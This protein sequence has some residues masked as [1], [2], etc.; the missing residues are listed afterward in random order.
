MKKGPKLWGTMFKGTNHCLNFNIKLIKLE[1]EIIIS[2][3]NNYHTKRKFDEVNLT[4]RSKQEIQALIF[5]DYERKIIAQ[6]VNK[7]DS[8][9][10]T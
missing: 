1:A 7:K 8:K 3:E 5:E 9:D 6:Y 10:E 2:D 4:A